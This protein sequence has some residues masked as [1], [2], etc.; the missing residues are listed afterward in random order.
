MQHT[1]AIEL[2]GTPEAF[3]ETVRAASP[4]KFK[5]YRRLQNRLA[6]SGTLRMGAGPVA[7]DL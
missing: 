2:S 4:K 3:L 7:G 6:E 1:Y 5:N